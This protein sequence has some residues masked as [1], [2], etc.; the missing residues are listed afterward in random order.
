MIGRVQAVQHPRLP[1]RPA[2]PKPIARARTWFRGEPHDDCPC[3]DRDAIRAGQHWP[4]PAVVA[5]QDSTIVIPPDW[6]ARCDRFG[7]ILITALG[8]TA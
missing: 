4:G 1:K 6:A 5:G 3:Y 7:N 2:Q 8:A